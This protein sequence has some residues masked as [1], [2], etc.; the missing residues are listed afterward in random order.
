MNYR[1]YFLFESRL[2]S[3]SCNHYKSTL[4]NKRHSIGIQRTRSS[5]EN[6]LKS[7]FNVLFDSMLLSLNIQNLAV[8]VPKPSSQLS[9]RETLMVIV[10]T[11][12]IPLVRIHFSIAELVRVVP[13]IMHSR[14]SLPEFKSIST[15]H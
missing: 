9:K 2:K 6:L 12:K 7:S 1:L 5:T 15:A 14:T 4:N 13:R 10:D 11:G 3:T 8:N